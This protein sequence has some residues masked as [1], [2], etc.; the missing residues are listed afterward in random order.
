MWTYDIYKPIRIKIKRKEVDDAHYVRIGRWTT[1][2]G[3]IVSIGTAYLV[4]QFASIMDYVQALFSFFIAPLFGTVVLGMLWKRATAA[5][6]FWGLLAG[7]F[8]S[9]GMYVVVKINPSMLKVFALS[10]DAKDMAENMYRALW[11]WLICVAVTVIV[12]YLTKPKTEA[13]LTNLVRG[14]TELPSE[15]D[16]PL[17]KRPIFWAGVVLVVFII[18]NIIFW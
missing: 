13:E 15:G 1:I 10:S 17:I 11:S 6:G 8:S 9:V 2:L 3:V 4:Q 18:L 12:S 5:G 14:C 7:I 16:L